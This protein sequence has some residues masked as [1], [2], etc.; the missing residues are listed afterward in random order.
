MDKKNENKIISKSKFANSELEN[1][2]KF[3]N[4]LIWNK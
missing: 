1:N 2:E 4:R 3:I